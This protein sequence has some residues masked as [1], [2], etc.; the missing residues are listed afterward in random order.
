MSDYASI[1][2][3]TRQA[4]A[5]VSRLERA[6]VQA[7]NDAAI[8][9]NFRS[10]KRMAERYQEELFIAAQ[11]YHIDICQYKLKPQ[12]ENRFPLLGVSQS[13][14]TFQELFPLIYAALTEGAKNTAHLSMP[15]RIQTELEFGYSYSGS[16]GVVLF[17]PSSRD[18]FST[19]F[20]QTIATIENLVT[21][22]NTD[23]VLNLS[24]KLGRAI[25]NKA[26]G[27]SFGNYNADFSVDINW[28]K[29]NGHFA[30]RAIERTQ[31]ARIADVIGMTSEETINPFEAT[32]ILVGVDVPTRWFH[33]VVPDGDSF[34]GTFGPDISMVGTIEVNRRYRGRFLERIVRH[35]ATDR[36]QRRYELLEL[37]PDPSA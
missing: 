17:V 1:L 8:E 7:P 14:E 37:E 12:T 4:Y 16:L 23:E 20:D 24:K 2:E 6:M 25:V 5:A 28:R 9:M 13:L 18:F 34:K 3:K 10:R 19:K 21:V 26:Y 11:E 36:A 27:W 33:F 29:S 35:L 15:M 32:G 30:G 31:L 22:S